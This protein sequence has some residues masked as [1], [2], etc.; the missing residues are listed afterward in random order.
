MKKLTS[1]L[2]AMLVVA[3]VT[4]LFPACSPSPTGVYQSSMTGDEFIEAFS[5]TALHPTNTGLLGAAQ[6][7]NRPFVVE[8]NKWT[9]RIPPA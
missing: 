9:W 4:S 6:T 2:A 5:V 3:I 8:L 7:A 1:K